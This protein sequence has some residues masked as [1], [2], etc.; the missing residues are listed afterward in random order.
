MVK[1]EMYNRWVRI[2]IGLARL[3]FYY[4]K[5]RILQCSFYKTYTLKLNPPLFKEQGEVKERE[6]KV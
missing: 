6:I 3:E 1:S 4:L 2:R 5:L